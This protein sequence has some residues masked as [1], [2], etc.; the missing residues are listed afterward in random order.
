VQDSRESLGSIC[1]Q[2]IFKRVA[3]LGGVEKTLKAME[4]EI[5]HAINT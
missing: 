5:W 1:S 4:E 3:L 2:S